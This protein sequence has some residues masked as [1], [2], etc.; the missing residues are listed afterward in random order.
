[1]TISEMEEL[2][3]NYGLV[4]DIEIIV[5]GHLKANYREAILSEFGLEF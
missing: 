1:M 4:T 3:E 5:N 2:I